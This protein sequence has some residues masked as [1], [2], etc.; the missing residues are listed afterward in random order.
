MKPIFKFSL[1]TCL[2]AV[3][4]SSCKDNQAEDENYCLDPSYMV[5][6]TVDVDI[7]NKFS[8]YKTLDTIYRAETRGD[9]A[10]YPMYYVAAYPVND[11]LPTV[12]AS[13]YDKKVPIKLHPS[14]YTLMS[15]VIYY[16]DSEKHGYNFYDDDFSELLLKNKYNYKGAEDP[17]KLA[18]R[19]VETK[20]I[21]Y[22]MKSTST[23]AKPIM[24]QY[25]IVATDTAKNFVPDRVVVT[26]DKLPSAIHGRTGKINWWWADIF[27]ESH[28]G[29]RDA[30]GQF[31]A[32]DYVLAH[33]DEEITVNATI[34]IYDY[35]GHLC[36]RKK[37]VEIPLKNGGITTLKGDFYSVRELDGTETT[38]S[39]ISIKTEWDA[40][41][42]IEI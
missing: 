8:P 26:Y 13:S 5:P 14:R 24:A 34:E 9:V 32:S 40:T 31:L 36:A 3:S 18:W 2:L 12:I 17:Y 25:K 10:P 23:T 4:L 41:F 21:A 33:D 28:V 20:N 11:L 39:G 16:A 37:N 42:E 27:Y 19:G 1:Y 22:N 7:D 15:W 6:L 30:N 29:K 38:G 35:E